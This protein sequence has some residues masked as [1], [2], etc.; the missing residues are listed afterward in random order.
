MSRGFA[1]NSYNWVCDRDPR[2]LSSCRSTSSWAQQI[3]DRKSSSGYS[4][5]ESFNKSL[6]N[7]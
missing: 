7:L 4:S 1:T 2:S 5:R 6:E 3:S